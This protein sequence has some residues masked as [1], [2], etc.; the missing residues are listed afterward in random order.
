M[1]ITMNGNEAFE[2]FKGE[3]IKLY[4]NCKIHDVLSHKYDHHDLP[5]SYSRASKRIDF[6]LCSFNLPTYISSR[7]IQY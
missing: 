5:N 4:I 3:I 7:G 1:I 2:P 6:I